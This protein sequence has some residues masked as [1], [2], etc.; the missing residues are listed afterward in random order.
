MLTTDHGKWQWMSATDFKLFLTGKI[1]ESAPLYEE[2]SSKGLLRANT[3]V[4]LIAQAVRKRKNHLGIGPVLHQIQLNDQHGW[5]TIETAKAIIDH[6]MQSTAAGLHFELIH[7]GGKI[8]EGVIEFIINYCIENK[9]EHKDLQWVLSS[10][11]DQLSSASAK[12]LAQYHCA[13][14]TTCMAQ[15]SHKTLYHPSL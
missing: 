2:L 5:L 11:L 7:Q 1:D 15:R 6:A 8:D 9:Y 13:L 4:E 10:P 3:D 14:H 12:V